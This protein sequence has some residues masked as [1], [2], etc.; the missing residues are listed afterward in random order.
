MIFAGENVPLSDLKG[1]YSYINKELQNNELVT[2]SGYDGMSFMQ[3]DQ[4]NNDVLFNFINTNSLSYGVSITYNE[5]LKAF[6][7]I[8]SLSSR[9]IET[10]PGEPPTTSIVIRDLRNSF[11]N[12]TNNGLVVFKGDKIFSYD[13]QYNIDSLT[14]LS[15]I[16][17]EAYTERKVFDNLYFD[18][19]IY[20]YDGNKTKIMYKHH[21]QIIQVHQQ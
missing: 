20:Q 9:N 12:P 2:D 18:L 1:I 14:E 21:I 16:V 11:I 8:N 15:S 5:L 4:I 19:D 6:V 3:Y 10:V 17:N 7:S 13:S